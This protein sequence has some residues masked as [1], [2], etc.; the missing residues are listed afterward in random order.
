[1]PKYSLGKLGSPSEIRQFIISERERL[2]NRRSLNGIVFMHEHSDLMDAAISQILHQAWVETAA[3][4][5]DR[6]SPHILESVSLAATGGYGRRELCPFSDIDITFIVDDQDD[7]Q[8]DLLV[9]NVYRLL[10]DVFLNG[11][12]LKV[13]YSYR[14]IDDIENLPLDT[15][16]ALLDA[17][18]VSGG[19]LLFDR[20]YSGILRAISPAEFV[21]GHLEQRAI[22][23]KQWGASPYLV[24][25]NIK[26]G[27]GGL[28]DLQTA[29]W[30]AQVAFGTSR[31]DVWLALRAQGI[32]SDEEI[33]WIEDAAEFLAK[34]RNKLHI[35]CGRDTDILYI[36]RQDEISAVLGYKRRAST[37]MANYFMHAE[38]IAGIYRKVASACHDQPLEI[39][40]GLV[41]QRKEIRLLDG[42]LLSRDPEVIIRIFEHAMMLGLGLCRETADSL[43]G[44]VASSRPPHLKKTG[45]RIAKAFLRVLGQPHAAQAID[46]MSSVGAIQWLIPEFGRIMHLI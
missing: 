18:R 42:G 45:A 9:K 15:H 23:G 44:Y 22:I 37:L 21:F 8:I 34:V 36:D 19:A 28:R 16:T 41:V 12:G 46:S 43:R 5:G 24:E 2:M 27:V 6:I 1:M 25:A 10:M 7:A 13:G 40:P 35:A 11:T 3:E 32:I 39:E 26:E 20:F 30:I 14:Y 29:R 17:R 33:K 38:H 4:V 31:S